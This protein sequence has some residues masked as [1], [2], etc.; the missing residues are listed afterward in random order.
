MYIG[1]TGG[2]TRERIKEHNRDIRFART[3]TSAV[4]E[5]ANEM[6]HI[7]IWS[8]VKFNDRDP[9]WYTRRVKEAIYVRLHPNSIS[10]DSGIEISEAWI[11]TVKQHSNRS[12]RICMGTPSNNRNILG[13]EKYQWQRTNML[14]IA[15]RKQSIPS[16]DEDWQYCS[17]NV[18]INRKSDSIVRQTNK[19]HHCFLHF[20]IVWFILFPSF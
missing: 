18:A 11:P 15:T 19:V 2:S 4:P 5:Y 10:R 14:Q 16:P 13:I 7:P 8:K 6:G 1:E 9:H 3:Q 20:G 17:R 12:V